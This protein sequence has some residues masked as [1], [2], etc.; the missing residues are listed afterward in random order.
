LPLT[1]NGKLN[2]KALPLL[3]SATSDAY[4]PPVTPTQVLL[5]RIWSEVLG[6]AQVGLDDDFFALGGHS[7]LAVRVA[8]RVGE[9][10][11]R[12][13]ELGLLFA[14]PSPVEMAAQLDHSAAAN[15]DGAGTLDALQDL[16]DS[17]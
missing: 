3:T 2:R 6:A 8:S 5:C 4:R 16:M 15:G 1:S 11:G 9:A 10:L 7:L 17:L 14:H 13:I 12:K